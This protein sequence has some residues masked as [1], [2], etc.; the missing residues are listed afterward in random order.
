MTKIK[1][2][3]E[4]IINDIKVV[5]PEFVM[6][7]IK[8]GEPKVIAKP[9]SYRRTIIAVITGAIVLIIIGVFFYYDVILDQS[10]SVIDLIGP[11]FF[12]FVLGGFIAQ[13][14]DG[15]LG[16]AYGVSASTFLM[17]F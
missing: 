5:E 11:E 4:V 17:S 12:I 10:Q 3:P 6:D 14:S 8:E 13:M 2:Q 1:E 16:M 15:S 7:E 9:I